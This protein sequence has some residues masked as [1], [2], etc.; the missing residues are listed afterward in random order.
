MDILFIDTIILAGVTD[1]SPSLEALPPRGPA[2][3]RDA[4]DEWAFINDTL[5]KWAQPSA[6]HKWKIVAGHYPGILKT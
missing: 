1:P 5:T 4:E 6:Q 2:S 3:L